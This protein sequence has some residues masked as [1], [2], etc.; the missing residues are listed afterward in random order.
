M[1]LTR[2]RREIIKNIFNDKEDNIHFREYGFIVEGCVL[3][4]SQH[5]LIMCTLNELYLPYSL[6]IIDNILYPM[7][8]T[9]TNRADDWDFYRKIKITSFE[10]IKEACYEL[11]KMFR[12]AKINYKYETIEQDF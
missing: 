10:E 4:T 1:K 11:L 8:E 3:M 5:S 12:K 2:T 9:G 6:K 7:D